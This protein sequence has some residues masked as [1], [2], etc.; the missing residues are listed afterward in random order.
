MVALKHS[1]INVRISMSQ[2]VYLQDD[3]SLDNCHDSHRGD[4]YNIYEGNAWLVKV[5][6]DSDCIYFG[7]GVCHQDDFPDALFYNPYDMFMPG[8]KELANIV[9]SAKGIASSF[10]FKM[11]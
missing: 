2:E 3:E 7:S 8:V 9:V 4:K 11:I 1:S 6:V 5:T 10:I